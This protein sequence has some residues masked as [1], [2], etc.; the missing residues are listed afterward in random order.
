MESLEAKVNGYLH[1]NARARATNEACGPFHIGLDDNNANP[2][3]NYA[4]PEAGATVTAADIE[5]LIAAFAKR[6]RTPRLEFAPGGAPGVEEALLAAGFEVQQRLPFMVVTAEELVGP[7]QLDGIEVLVLDTSATDEELS[8]A[9]LAQHE[10][11]E[12][13]DKPQDDTERANA[14]AG[15]RAMVDAGRFA[16]LARCAAGS[17]SAGVPMAAGSGGPAIAGT[18][19]I[20]GIGTRPAFRRRGAG[21][22]VT[23][24]LSRHLL[25][26][27]G[28]DCVW[29]SPAGPD[30]ERLYAS[31]GYRSLGEMLFIWKP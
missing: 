3:L 12:G 31:I 20:G 5:A 7:A 1:G 26:V 6:E 10:A 19:E 24:A 4:V 29:L 11:F 21:A 13:P 30:Q 25:E 8:G 9:A 18:T 14:L 2:F 15:M 22:A 16:S 28:L 17:A 27:A 23:A